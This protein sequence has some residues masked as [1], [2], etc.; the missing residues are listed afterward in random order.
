MH[1]VSGR[2]LRRRTYYNTWIIVKDL[3]QRWFVFFWTNHAC[4]CELRLTDINKSIWCIIIFK[5][6][7]QLMHEFNNQESLAFICYLEY[8]IC[9]YFLIEIRMDCVIVISCMDMNSNE[10]IMFY[11]VWEYFLLICTVKIKCKRKMKIII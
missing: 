8:N 5:C 1:L 2:V 6:I 3:I 10:I 9:L 4:S 11:N 7:H